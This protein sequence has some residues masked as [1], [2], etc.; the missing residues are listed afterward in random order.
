MT[1]ISMSAASRDLDSSPIACSADALRW[2][3]LTKLGSRRRQVSASSSALLTL[4]SFKKACGA[5]GEGDGA[6]DGTAA[7]THLRR[8]WVGQR[9][10]NRHARQS[11]ADGKTG[12]GRAEQAAP[13]SEH[14]LHSGHSG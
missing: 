13:G 14:R 2:Y 10:S 3:P 4:F 12:T 6:A 8:R 11:G 7:E 1:P 9:D 5:S